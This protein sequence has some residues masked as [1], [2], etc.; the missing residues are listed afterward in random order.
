MK[1][2]VLYLLSALLIS[3]C[4]SIPTEIENSK[5]VNLDSTKKKEAINLA[6]DCKEHFISKE[7]QPPCP[8]PAKFEHKRDGVRSDAKYGR[9]CGADHPGLKHPIQKDESRLTEIER[10]ELAFDYYRIRPIDDIDTICQAHDV[11]W[12]L[13]PGKQLSCN[14]ELYKS[15]G[16]VRKEEDKQVGFFE[17]DTPHFRCRHLA[18]DIAIASDFMQGSLTDPVMLITNLITSPLG[19]VYAFL[20][21]TGRSDGLYPRENELCNVSELANWQKE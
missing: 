1:K 18:M 13:N 6:V 19:L 7:P 16:I 17:V 14:E 15:M 10:K 9:F 4:K 3:A 12:L 21:E 20:L 2:A 8:P 5:L 11:C